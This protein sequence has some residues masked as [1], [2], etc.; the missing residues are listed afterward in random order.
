LW[1]QPNQK[2][3]KSLE[4]GRLPQLAMDHQPVRIPVS[5]N[6][7]FQ[8]SAHLSDS[9]LMPILRELENHVMLISMMGHHHWGY[10]KLPLLRVSQLACFSYQS[11]RF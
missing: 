7:R 10:P 4:Q 2:P 6:L 11:N 9:H 5:K 3:G 8:S 1:L